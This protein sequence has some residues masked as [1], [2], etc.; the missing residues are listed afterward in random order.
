MT[1]QELATMS[2]GRFSSKKNTSNTKPVTVEELASKST[3]RFSPYKTFDFN[4]YL[5]KVTS[6]DTNLTNYYNQN[7]TKYN[8]DFDR[9]DI[10]AM[11]KETQTAIGF[12]NYNK[13][14]LQNADELLD[15]LNN[16]NT[17]LNSW[18][19]SFGEMKTARAD[20]KDE[21]AWNTAVRTGTLSEM[22]SADLQTE[23]DKVKKDREN[24]KYVDTVYK[25][26]TGAPGQAVSKEAFLENANKVKEIYGVDVTGAVD[27]IG[28]YRLN[29]A[30]YR[31]GKGVEVYVELSKQKAAYT[32]TIDKLKKDIHSKY[33]YGD[34][35][36]LDKIIGEDM[37]TVSEYL[38]SAKKKE[39]EAATDAQYQGVDALNNGVDGVLTQ[40][41]PNSFDSYEASNKNA[42]GTYKTD[43]LYSSW[44]RQA[45]SSQ[46]VQR[47]IDAINKEIDV[48]QY[49]DRILNLHSWLSGE[50]NYQDIFWLTPEGTQDYDELALWLKNTT[51]VDIT[52]ID[53]T[54][55]WYGKDKEKFDALASQLEPYIAQYI[56]ADSDI[57]DISEL[58]ND[59]RARMMNLSETKSL[60]IT[61][62]NKFELQEEIKS[63]MTL[64]D[65]A[66]NSKADTAVT[67]KVYQMIAD[68][69]TLVADDEYTDEMRKENT[70]VIKRPDGG[71]NEIHTK[72]K[73][74]LG[75]SKDE[76]KY[77]V[78]T[79]E[80]ES[81]YFYLYK[82]DKKK[83]EEYLEKLTP[84]LNE[85]VNKKLQEYNKRYADEHPV[86]GTLETWWDVIPNDIKAMVGNLND[87]NKIAKGE[88][89]DVN[90]KYKRGNISTQTIRSVV[91]SNQNYIGRV[92]YNGL[93]SGVDN[94]IRMVF[95]ASVGSVCGLEGA[96]L[97]KFV[98]AASSVMMGASVTQSAI[99]E[100]IEKGY[101]DVEAFLYG[102]AKGGIESLTE[103]YSIDAILKG[104][105]TIAKTLAKSFVAEGSE[106]VASNIAGRMLDLIVDGDQAELRRRMDELVKAGY[107]EAEAFSMIA[108]ELI[109]EDVESFITGGL[110]GL[111]M[112]GAGTTIN[113]ADSFKQSA[114]IGTEGAQAL[115]DEGVAIGNELAIETQQNGGN[116]GMVR[117]AE[118]LQENK[119]IRAEMYQAGQKGQNEVKTTTAQYLQRMGENGD[120]EALS[121]AVSNIVTGQ[122]TQADISLVTQNKNAQTAVELLTDSNLEA[123][124]GGIEA[125]L[126][127]VSAD[128]AVTDEIKKVTNGNNIQ[129][130]RVNAEAGLVRDE[131]TQ[132]LDAE[133]MD[134]LDAVAKAFGVKVVFKDKVN[135]GKDDA[136]IQGSVVEIEKGTDRALEYLIGHEIMHRIRELSPQSFQSFAN[137][138]K[139]SRYSEYAA[140]LETTGRVYEEG[141]D[142]D[143]EAICNM[144]GRIA[145]DEKL[146]EKFIEQNKHD[147]GIL[148]ALLDVFKKIWNTVTKAEQR[149]INDAV[150]QLEKALNEGSK[151]A[152]RLA[153]EGKTETRDS[154]D[155]EAQKNNTD[156][157]VKSLIKNAKNE[158]DD[159]SAF[160]R[161]LIE[162]KD[163]NV[164]V[165]SEEQLRALV[166]EAFLDKSSKRCLHLGAIPQQ[167]IEKINVSIEGLPHDL[168]GNLFKE[169][170]EQSLT[171]GQDDI[172][173]MVAE[174]KSMTEEDVYEYINNLPILVNSFDKVKFSYNIRGNNKLRS[175]R[176]EKTLP[177]GKFYALDVV[178]RKKS[179]LETITI[180][181]DKEDY[182][183]KKYADSM[184]MQN[185][186]AS[187]SETLESHT[188]SNPTVSKNKPVVN[189]NS[190]QNDQNNSSPAIKSSRKGADNF[191]TERKQSKDR[192]VVFNEL[193]QEQAKELEAKLK[194]ALGENVDLRKQ[195]KEAN[196]RAE[197]FK[198]QLHRTPELA[199]DM[200][201]LKARAKEYLADYKGSELDIN[202]LASRMADWRL[203][204]YDIVLNS[205]SEQER[206]NRWEALREKIGVTCGEILSNSY[207]RNEEADTDY[208]II[209]DYVGK[210]SGVT[211]HI[212]EELKAEIEYSFGSYLDFR[213]RFSKHVNFK[214]NSGTD[215]SS[216]YAELAQN[217]PEYFNES[218]TTAPAD[219]LIQI[220]EVLESLHNVYY[221]AV[222]NNS[223]LEVAIDAQADMI[224][225][226]L[227]DAPNAKPT[228]AD[229]QNARLQTMH[230]EA[231]KAKNDALKAERAEKQRTVEEI[232]EYYRQRDNALRNSKNE[233]EAKQALLNNAR[234]LDR[235]FNRSTRAR[236]AEIEAI[237]GNLDLASLSISKKKI[238]EFDTVADLARELN[239]PIGQF[240]ESIQDTMT[241]LKLKQIG[242]MNIVEVQQLNNAVLALIHAIRTENELI[243]SADRRDRRIQGMETLN[244]IRAV[245]KETENKYEAE[246]KT[247]LEKAGELTGR[248]I[249]YH[250]DPIRWVR[251]LT[252]YVDSDPLYRAFLTLNDGQR[253]MLLYQQ[254]AEEMFRNFM[255]D[256]K[257]MKHLESTVEIKG[258]DV[259]TGE[260]TTVKITP[261]MRI[262]LYMHS[263]NK[264]NM[265]HIEG[266]GVFIAKAKLVKKYGYKEKSFAENG[267]RLTEDSIREICFDMTD[268]ERA[269]AAALQRY[270][271]GFAKD[272]I[273]NVSEKLVGYPKALVKNY[274][275]INPHPDFV[276]KDKSGLIQDK[277]L[278]GMG[279]LKERENSENPIYLFDA[280]TVLHRH[281]NEGSRYV[282]MAVPISN[283]NKLLSVKNGGYDEN[284]VYK[285]DSDGVWHAMSSEQKKYVK[286][287][288]RD[289]QNP[290]NNDKWITN[291]LSKSASATLVLNAGVAVKQAA[292]FP[293]A[294]AEIGWKPLVKTMVSAPIMRDILR[295]KNVPDNSIQVMNENTPLFWYRAKGFNGIDNAS[296]TINP[297][298]MP[299]ALNWIQGM[300]LLTTK[301]LYKSCQYYV[302][303]T[304]HLEPG[305][306]EY[307]DAV[308]EK[309]ANVIERTQPNYTIMQR[310]GMLRG[311][312][313]VRTVF[314]YM[315]QPYQNFGILADCVGNM[316]A[317]YKQMK[318]NPTAET[319]EAYAEAKRAFARGTS[320]LVVAQVVYTAMQTAWNLLRGKKDRYKD[321]EEEITF[322]SF[323]KGFGIDFGSAMANIIPFGSTVYETVLALL[324]DGQFYGLSSAPVEIINDIINSGIRLFKAGEEEKAYKVR[325]VI[326]KLAVLKGIPTKNIRNLFATIGYNS[327]RIFKNE[328]IADYYLRIWDSVVY[329]KD[330]DG[331]YKATSD[332]Y[333]MLFKAY[334]DDSKNGKEAYNA[335]RNH[336]IKNGVSEDKIDKAI[337][338]RVTKYPA[339]IK[340][341]TSNV[342]KAIDAVEDMPYYKNMTD[343][344][345]ES[346][347][348][349]A[350]TYYKELLKKEYGVDSNIDEEKPLR[351]ANGLAEKGHNPYK[352]WLYMATRDLNGN[353][354]VDSD[355]KE[356]TF[357]ALGITGAYKNLIQEI[358]NEKNKKK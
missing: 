156:D 105:S 55:N 89:I 108:S 225:G 202:V 304:M 80:E 69:H 251:K 249:D 187:T 145:L 19:K 18:G 25:M 259:N 330:K 339:G 302:K 134:K 130:K 316:N 122:G 33:N 7:G 221:S 183:K 320:S 301:A 347:E 113:Y 176:F 164:I 58:N 289:L 103:K 169:D 136:A 35:R 51:G 21:T 83:A 114:K 144:A 194:E 20:Y 63:I 88:G 282:G 132:T 354:S 95:A 250:L 6:F 56:G 356:K 102:V 299:T 3:G 271:D 305:T 238:K 123:E 341:I 142:Y 146:L 193:A 186:Q 152:E 214:L 313:F 31:S 324:D 334:V 73:Y 120:V 307:N 213:K 255:S 332:A 8:F 143:E 306:K 235:M 159:Y 252:G 209:A 170:R 288:L 180:F 37:V 230:A 158:L 216:V 211:L 155:Y 224:I 326:D 340:T 44:R 91:A 57:E 43:E 84:L 76:N 318:V 323:M 269:F 239:V 98:S 233:R 206:E 314:R 119:R 94:G 309:Y 141:E 100:G 109:A 161:Q 165:E 328:M 167:T 268:K 149:K 30:S 72:P 254:Q 232:K 204:M 175:I 131:Y 106:E 272:E 190:M 46:D 10:D 147:K 77:Y 245:Q 66:D 342:D 281:I 74:L 262:S 195:L 297:A 126:A 350:T 241:R 196:R 303:D 199:P 62:K 217:I 101:T 64:P 107:S 311:N 244:N 54:K 135:M 351:I 220:C 23:L 263:R 42:D 336:M 112:G 276:T 87:F 129:V 327:I 229:K 287:L 26:L 284:G 34:I 68:E 1:V 234:I 150:Y 231:V 219:Q 14:N 333:D 166:K 286:N 308:A 93:T 151:V 154:I 47:G 243:D 331:S 212:T 28:D 92:F 346:Y 258:F 22:S 13:A 121:T 178:S 274:F 191:A 343:K 128:R 153:K 79:A 298:Q 17:Y 291:L 32:T 325:E 242:D 208:K 355:E 253:K 36:S 59:R 292:S 60:M 293:T 275:P 185:A 11:K 237:I 15:Y 345:K 75:T 12:V 256:K 246:E 215:V 218:T 125:N 9:F 24:Y 300:D 5:N 50:R 223:T 38:D 257:F 352:Y 222:P 319:K 162:S 280:V 192:Q 177:N 99:I 188:S 270:F 315:T 97:T 53:P 85:R 78:M 111:F 140:E 49:G 61:D 41:N 283:I 29:P 348:D 104:G 16:V 39:S 236:R 228:F 160:R 344:Q 127:K 266:G 203:E 240:D 157:G 248:V 81:V 181:M 247:L 296:I 117:R 285:K 277:T 278:E 4:G 90:D 260:V 71:T 265:R 168:K 349:R 82:Q 317:K 189:S 210:K 295:L 207:Y 273:N 321:D 198:S 67:D 184:P 337:K 182:K 133:E 96:A 48:L 139:V 200:K 279:S 138:V 52:G 197:H 312:I 357:K 118:I 137:A 171:I 163:S 358:E 173:H 294:A 205:E 110:S 65:F 353:G 264:Q 310:N 201:A 172:R 116:A 267:I 70:V 335:I 322:L 2:T 45:K 124:E 338:E 227:L 148:Q 329:Y 86:K 261:A 115:V 40:W 226:A 290:E 179:Q 174:K 27:L